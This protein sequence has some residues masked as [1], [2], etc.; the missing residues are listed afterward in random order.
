MNYD[1]IVDAIFIK[2][3]DVY[4]EVDQPTGR[5][6]ITLPVLQ[7]FTE[8]MTGDILHRLTRLDLQSLTHAQAR[9]VIEWFLHKLSG[10]MGLEHITYEP[11]QLQLLDFGYNSGGPRAI[12]WLQRVLNIPRTGK[13]DANTLAVL[14]KVS[15]WLTHHALIGARLQMIHRWA[16]APENQKYEDGLVTRALSFSSLQV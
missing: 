15:L 12:R 2:E 6:G 7:A 13:M 5:G 16:D 14:G 4:A 1:S 11:L 9:E 10:E 3:G 8:A